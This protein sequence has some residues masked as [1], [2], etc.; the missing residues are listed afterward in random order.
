MSVHEIANIFSNLQEYTTLLLIIGTVTIMSLTIAVSGIGSLLW[1]MLFLFGITCAVLSLYIEL[2]DINGDFFLNL[3]TELLG[4]MIILI[5]L[6]DTI[7]QTRMAFPLVALLVIFSTIP[8]ESSNETM[9]PLLLNISAEIL[10]AFL[11]MVLLQRRDWLWNNRRKKRQDRIQRTRKR[12]QQKV[13]KLKQSEKQT[14]LNEVQQHLSEW[15]Q[16]QDSW[17]IGMMIAGKNEADIKRKL[18]QLHTIMDIV[19]VKQTFKDQENA[20]IQ[21]HLIAQLRPQHN[22]LKAQATG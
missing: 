6:N 17:D 13:E 10:G 11:I 3:G 7:V 14:L 22:P 8:I 19:T 2:D 4:T 16:A 15:R 21:C 1:R 9:Q 20:L 5:I 12:Y 18:K